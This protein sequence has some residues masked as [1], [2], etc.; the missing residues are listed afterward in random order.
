MDKRG[1]ILII[2][3]EGYSV[4]MYL[5]GFIQLSSLLPHKQGYI[6]LTDF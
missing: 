2:I 1:A 3:V 5:F 6:G 4:L